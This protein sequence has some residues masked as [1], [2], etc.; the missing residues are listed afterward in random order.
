VAQGLEAD[1]VTMSQETDVNMLVRAS[2]VAPDW[3]ARFPDKS[4]PYT[5]IIVFLVRDGN[6][7][8]IQD[9]S[10]LVKPGVEVILADPKTSGEGRY[11][12]L[13]AWAWGQTARGG[14]AK[15]ARAFVE[16]LLRRVRVFEG[17]GRAAAEAFITRRTGDVLLTFESEALR[18]ARHRRPDQF[19]VV[20][21]SVS[22]EAEFPVAV[23][24]KTGV[25]Q[26]G[27]ETAEEYLGHLWSAEAQLLAAKHFYRPRRAE[28]VRDGELPSVS[29]LSVD[30]LF[31]GWSA[32]Q[33][34]HFDDGGELD[35]FSASATL[36]STE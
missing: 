16:A 10:D 23:V 12:Y 5:S 29:L 13:A 34:V 14:G 17:G 35:G 1:V 25:E 20:V 30:D 33:R 6:P 15:A 9:W 3:R 28:M 4:S 36:R 19:E 24:R 11:A 21:P 18:L 32:A 22:I 31:G 2:R 7:K 26:A 8:G 27:G